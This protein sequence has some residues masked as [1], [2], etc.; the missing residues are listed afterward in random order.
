VLA[1]GR[2]VPAGGVLAG[3]QRNPHRAGD[4]QG[5]RSPD[6]QPL[7]RGDQVFHCRQSQ[8]DGAAGQRG[9][10]DDDN[11]PVDPVDRAHATHRTA[12]MLSTWPRVTRSPI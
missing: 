5:R 11:C 7:D 10:V 3:G 12:R 4:A 2:Y 6:G 9:L 1:R 8:L